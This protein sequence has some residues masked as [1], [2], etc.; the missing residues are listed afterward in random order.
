MRLLDVSL[1]WHLPVPTGKET[2]DSKKRRGRLSVVSLLVLKY[3]EDMWKKRNEPTCFRSFL[4]FRS[5][6]PQSPYIA[7]CPL[8]SEARFSGQRCLPD[9]H[10]AVIISRGD[11]CSVRRPGDREHFTAM[12]AV[13]QPGN[14]CC[15]LPDLDSLAGVG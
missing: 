1:C 14:T 4:F 9:A 8:S 13:G 12:I 15:A 7:D 2:L 5:V 6:A 10:D 11:V 3:H